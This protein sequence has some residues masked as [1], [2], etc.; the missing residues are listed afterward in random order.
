[1]ETD[2]LQK[3]ETAAIESKMH[4]QLVGVKRLIKFHMEVTLF[5][6]LENRYWGLWI[7]SGR[8]SDTLT[9]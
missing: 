5:G 4:I 3:I 9:K 6:N 8:H 1:M 7:M 2:I